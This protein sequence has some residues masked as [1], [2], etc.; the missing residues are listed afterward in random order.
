MEKKIVCLGGGTG[1]AAILDGL[2]DYNY[3]ITA[4][5][6]V[7]DNG[8]YSGIIR[9]AMN[10][11][12][13]GDSRNVLVSLAEDSI[14]TKLLK[15]RFSEG[16]LSG[17]SLGN[18]I[19]AAL[20][21]VEGDFNK[22]VKTISKVI[23]I[24]G[25][26]L[27][28]T[29]YST[30][31][32]AELFDGGVVEGEWDI[33]KK[34]KSQIKRLFLK[35]CVKPTE[36]VIKVIEEADMIV[37]CPGSLRTGIIPILLVNGVVG[38]IKRSRAIKVSICNIMTH[39][40]QT[41]NFTV[42]MH[43]NEIKKYCNMNFDYYLV[44]SGKPDKKILKIYE[45]SGAKP[46]EIDNING[47]L[48]IIVDNFVAYFDTTVLVGLNRPP[49]RDILAFPHYIRHNSKKVAKILMEIIK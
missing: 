20:T 26:V 8:G 27:P 1:Q 7:T 16:A 39:P 47:A 38:A 44:N 2:K 25:R 46:V 17:V 24:K 5:V 13:M 41:D 43:L 36:G 3:E 4:I 32:C 6:G 31:I 19:L 23:K 10:L 21:R 14:I 40:G 42:S 33:I 30:H 15:Y 48:H 34:S 12:Q 22:A 29:N 49:G 45:E 28:V 18:L 37:F 35:D 11:P 9:Q